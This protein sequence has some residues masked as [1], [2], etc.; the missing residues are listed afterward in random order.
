[1]REFWDLIRDPAARDALG[2]PSDGLAVVYGGLWTVA[3]FF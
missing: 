1:M 2:W 3:T